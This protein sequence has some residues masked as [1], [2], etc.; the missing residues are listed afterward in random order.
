MKG[1]VT[2]GISGAIAGLLLAML[3]HWYQPAD[4]CPKAVP[5]APGQVACDLKPAVWPLSVEL[6]TGGFV[7]CAGSSLACSAYMRSRKQTRPRRD[8]DQ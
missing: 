8:R 5:P 2:W 6:G 7:L 3:V 1:V 4:R